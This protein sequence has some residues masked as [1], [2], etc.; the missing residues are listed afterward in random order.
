MTFSTPK[1][2]YQKRGWQAYALWPMACAYQIAH[3]INQ[4][5]KKT[6]P[7]TASVPVICIGNAVAGGGGKTPTVLALYK[8]IRARNIAT[9][10]FIIT[11]GYGTSN[12]QSVQVNLEQ[13]LPKDV[14]DEP[15]L[16]AQHAPVVV[17]VDRQQSIE[18]AVENGAD[19]V[20]MDDGF[21]NQ[22]VKKDIKILVVDRN[23][24]FGNGFTL[25]AGPLREPLKRILPNTHAIVTIGPKFASDLPVFE[26]NLETTNKHTT[27][28]DYIGFC[29][30]GFPEKFKATLI[31]ENYNLI[32]WYEFPDHHPYSEQNI[33][34]MLD[35]AKQRNA[36]LI[37]T[38]KDFVKMPAQYK[39]MVDVLYIQIN[40]K[41]NEGVVTYLKDTL[42]N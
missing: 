10:P 19:L 38:E 30:I 35:E 20:L 37:T 7:Y 12:A 18:F 4:S 21:F 34:L 32:G 36:R 16:M 33:K 25:P 26:S 31:K 41:D 17:G 15:I 24:D 11:R 8:L 42:K 22:S 14:G 39:E 23:M 28:D 5:I 1:F 3:R 40:F 13:H 6:S 9:N 29:G 27:D 2:W